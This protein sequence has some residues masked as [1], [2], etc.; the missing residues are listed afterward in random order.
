MKNVLKLKLPPHR[1]TDEDQHSTYSDRQIYCENSAR[2][3][4]SPKS[5]K[6]KSQKS[7]S[8]EMK[9]K[10]EKGSLAL[11]N[12]KVKPSAKSSSTK[13]KKGAEKKKN[14]TPK[15][16]MLRKKK[17][18]G[19]ESND[20]IAK[21][22]KKIKPISIPQTSQISINEAN[23]FSFRRQSTPRQVDYIDEEINII[24]ETDSTTVKTDEPDILIARHNDSTIQLPCCKKLEREKPIKFETRLEKFRRSII[25]ISKVKE[26]SDEPLHYDAEM[27]PLRINN[28]LDIETGARRGILQ[29]SQ[30]LLTHASLDQVNLPLS[31]NSHIE[32]FNHSIVHPK[33]AREKYTESIVMESDLFPS[34][35]FS[36][37]LGTISERSHPVQNPQVPRISLSHL[38]S[39]SHPVERIAEE[40]KYN[41]SPKLVQNLEP[42][43]SSEDVE[44]DEDL[45][46]KAKNFESKN[47]LLEPQPNSPN[48]NSQEFGTDNDDD[49]KWAS[50]LPSEERRESESSR[51]VEI[52][53]E[54][55]SDDDND[56]DSSLESQLKSSP[57]IDI[58]KVEFQ[59]HEKPANITSKINTFLS[60][61][62]Y[63]RNIKDE[64][65]CELSSSA[66]LKTV[67]PGEYLASEDKIKDLLC[68]NE[69]YM[70][71]EGSVTISQSDIMTGDETLLANF[72]RGEFINDFFVIDKDPPLGDVQATTSLTLACF[73]SN[74]FVLFAQHVNSE[75][76][77]SELEIFESFDF[78]KNLPKLIKLQ[79]LSRCFPKVFPTGSVLIKEVSQ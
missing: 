43:D 9:N 48:N 75:L 35:I 79:L 13:P 22:M 33:C 58:N 65:L 19:S 63:L 70:I 16:A 46:Q 51:S 32:H 74:L 14:R 77:K 49:I 28:C 55:G 69:V 4:I 7:L 57:E 25:R 21:S 6:Q 47:T 60:K 61:I 41:S 11:M 56:E 20:D 15:K 76:I 24:E 26:I 29:I 17:I 73:P 59:R 12:K 45:L 66:F 30:L 78:T 10:R 42:I 34:S 64:L 53:V 62:F 2:F 36:S 50:A 31:V 37:K 18:I 1:S 3:S 38:S 23:I 54:A 72:T 44:L 39:F 68:S 8:K 71:L 52:E 67:A 5:S 27:T 40:L